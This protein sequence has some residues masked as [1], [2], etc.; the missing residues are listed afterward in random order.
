Y[1]I[2]NDTITVQE[3]R[4]SGLV[5]KNCRGP[6]VYKFSRPD[7]NTLAFVLVNDVCKPRIQ[8]VTRP[9]HRQ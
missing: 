4:H 9:W 3:T 5:A 6:G 2:A 8:N 7:A 1:T